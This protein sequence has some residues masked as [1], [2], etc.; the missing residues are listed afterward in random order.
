MAEAVGLVGGGDF[1]EGLG[2]AGEAEG[3]ELV[4]GRMVEQDRLLL[5]VVAR[6]ADVGVQDRRSVRGA[7]LRGTPIELVVEDGFD[8]AIGA[9]ADLDGAL[10]RGFE[11]RGAEGP[12][13]RTMPRQARKPCSGCGRCSRISSHSAA[14]AGPI[15]ARVRADALDRPVGVAAMAGG[16]VLGHGRV[17]AVAARSRICAAIRSPLRK[18]STVRAV[19]RTSTSAR[20]KR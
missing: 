8:R 16:H 20:A 18:T 15:S 6:A 14:V 13:S 9:R 11:A 5:M 7:L 1:G 4:E 12:A 10:G 19:S 17:L 2:H 3:V